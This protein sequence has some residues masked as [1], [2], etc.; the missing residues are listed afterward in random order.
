MSQTL[1]TLTLLQA[2]D[3]EYPSPATHSADTAHT[4]QLVNDSDVAT[5]LEALLQGRSLQQITRIDLAFPKFTDGRAF[6][7]AIQLRRRH[8]YSGTLR[9]TGDVLVDQLPHM[10]RCGFNEAVLAAG[11]S[12]EVAQR[13]LQN[14]QH[15]TAHYQGDALQTQP[16]FARNAIVNGG[17]VTA[18][19]TPASPTS[20]TSTGQA[21]RVYAQASPT[22]AAKLAHTQ[23]LLCQAAAQYTPLTQASSLGAEDVVI[24]HLLAQLQLPVDVFVL[25]TGALHAETLQLL[26][27]TREHSGLQV[28]VLEPQAEALV[29]FFAKEGP[30]AMYRSIALRKACCHLRKIE[31]LDRALQGYPAWITGLRREQSQAR[32]ETPEVDTTEARVKLNPLADWTTGDVW[33]YIGQHQVDYNPLHDQFYPSIG[34]APCTRAIS[35]GEDFRAGRWWWESEDAKECGLHVPHTQQEGS[36]V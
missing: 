28:R 13:V 4:L 35:L 20:A 23:T 18:T 12:P 1:S 2:S 34:C 10:L 6:S 26:Q 21:V 33:H 9:A 11:Q 16:L 36:P 30:Q 5:Q 27:R 15:Q 17:T 7:Q 25:N 29:Q 8:G 3:A 19:K 32:A 22:F 24:T 14:Y 31:P